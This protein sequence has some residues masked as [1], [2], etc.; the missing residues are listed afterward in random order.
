MPSVLVTGAGRGIGRSTALRLAERGWTVHA[1]VRRVADGEALKEEAG[2][3][4]E[5][6]ELDIT[7]ADQ[8]AALPR[9]LG[10]RLDAL[11]NNAGTVVSGPVEAVALDEVR[12]QLE[13]NVVA[14]VGGT[15]AGLALVGE[16]RGRVGFIR[17]GSG[18]G[19]APVP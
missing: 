2:R 18:R 3:G 13:L 8:V 7:D 6:L 9:T 5:P 19:G 4:I 10:G 12:E 14:Q 17:P 1:G 11:V 15:Q 16:A